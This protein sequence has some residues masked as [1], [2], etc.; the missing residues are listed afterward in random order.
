[1]G[2]AKRVIDVATTNNKEAIV[3]ERITFD[4]FWNVHVVVKKVL[5]AT[6]W[7]TSESSLKQNHTTFWSV[8]SKAWQHS[9]LL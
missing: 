9:S 5:E 6:R 8:V 7:S 4:D 2:G 3:V 1:L